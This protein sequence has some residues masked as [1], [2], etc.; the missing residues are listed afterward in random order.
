MFRKCMSDLSISKEVVSNEIVISN[1]IM[2]DILL[3]DDLILFSDSPTSL[4]KQIDGLLNFFSRKIGVLSMKLRPK[5]CTLAP[6]ET[7]T[8]ILRKK[9]KLLNKFANTNAFVLLF[10]RLTKE[11][12]I[13]FLII[14]GLFL[15]NLRTPQNDV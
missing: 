8:G 1:E 13:R 15:T 14:M 3:T 12:K 7:S 10:V 5:S 11:I 2:T 9:N 6:M 4:Q